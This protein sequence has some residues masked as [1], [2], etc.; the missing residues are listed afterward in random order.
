MKRKLLAGA[1][2]LT[3]ALSSVVSASGANILVDGLR[4]TASS[5]IINVEGYN[6]LE[7]RAV[8]EMLGADVSWNQY[9]MEATAVKDDMTVVVNMNDKTVKVNDKYVDMPA[10][11]QM[12]EGKV[13]VPVRC[14]AEAMDCK[15]DWD[16]MTQ[17]IKITTVDK[18]EYVL[19]N[20]ESGV[21]ESTTVYTFE[22][23][24]EMALKD[25]SSLK[26][27][28]DS[29]LYLED[30]KDQLVDNLDY[31]DTMDFFLNSTILD[32]ETTIADRT[33][34]ELSLQANME[35]IITVAR[36]IQSV[37]QQ[38]IL[39][40]TNKEMIEDGVEISLINKLNNI[41]QLETQISLLSESVEL[42][43]VNI[44]NLTLKNELG[45][46]S[47]YELETAKTT[48]K[49]N[50]ASLETL[51]LS[52]KTGKESLN[53]F[54][55]LPA[56]SNISVTY[57]EEMKALEDFKLEPFIMKQRESAPNIKVLKSQLE[58]ARYNNN[59]NPVMS[60]ELSS[61]TRND[62]KT[63]DRALADGQDQ[64]EENIRTAYNNINQLIQQ[65]KSL[66]LK[67]EQAKAD[68]NSVV[69]S[70]QAGMATELQVKQAKLGIVS[71]EKAVDDNM[72][73][74]NTLVFMLEK[75]Y[76]MG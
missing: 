56:T 3:M 5:N 61:S 66:R 50:E 47:D 51:K 9:K 45:Y 10:Q 48:Q 46:A 40:D 38:H 18:N 34:K 69:V 1:L 63:A 49:N 70:Y 72:M 60:N 33:A 14:I 68:Y 19:L 8:F 23:A 41:K 22:E 73:Q 42:G 57:N 43:K 53:V 12:V 76:L 74:Y 17:S 62:L 24:Y 15:V 71:A 37:D 29:V 39:H 52:L 26:S 35:S 16:S 31:L 25:S 20:T 30:L 67:V 65:D 6:L 13:Y 59:T 28:E 36:S 7:L 55:G 64:I 21:D 11:C 54:L 32:P 58:I 2:T 44:E 4:Q 27:L 75:P